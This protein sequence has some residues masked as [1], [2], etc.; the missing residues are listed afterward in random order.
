VEGRGAE[1]LGCDCAVNVSVLVEEADKSVETVEDASNAA[2]QA[3]NTTVTSGSLMDLLSKVLKSALDQ[4]DNSQDEGAESKSAHVVSVGPQETLENVGLTGDTIVAWEVLAT[5]V[6]GCCGADDRELIASHDE[7]ADPDHAE[8]HT[9]DHPV[10]TGGSVHVLRLELD[11]RYGDL[12]ISN[13]TNTCKAPKEEDEDHYP[14][15]EVDERHN[16]NALGVG[17]EISGGFNDSDRNFQALEVAKHDQIEDTSHDPAD[18]GNQQ[19][20]GSLS[21][22]FIAVGGQDILSVSV[23]EVSH[24][25]ER[26]FNHNESGPGKVNCT[27]VHKLDVDEGKEKGNENADENDPAGLVHGQVVAAGSE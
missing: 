18:R 21:V 25:S 9:R 15:C 4:P 2:E 8:G 19:E 23:G 27:P 20:T 10:G 5:E 26:D 7:R 14:Q 13:R 12:A 17:E 11:T 1:I 16:G 3:S 24:C 22:S 6:P